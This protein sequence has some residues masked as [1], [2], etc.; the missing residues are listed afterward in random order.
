[1]ESRKIFEGLGL[2]KKEVVERFLVVTREIYK[3]HPA[4]IFDE[5]ESKTEILI[6]PSYA[7]TDRDGKQPRLIVKAGSYNYHLMDTIYNNMSKEVKRNG[8]VAGY[9]HSQILNIPLTVL[10]HSYA[11]EE[12]SDLADEL[13]SL[14][15]YACRKM[16]SAKGLV[17]RGMQ[18]SETDLFNNDQKIYQT[19]ASIS[20]DVPWTTSTVDLSAPIQGIELSPVIEEP[21][22]FPTYRSPG[23]AVI[24]EKQ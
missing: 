12:S 14:V 7:D 18:V 8:S 1:M 4:Y 21:L 3:H 17:V 10:I 6:Y 5:D 11:E 9:E 16:Y 22:I 24:K 19:T 15:V 2:F 13:A 23:V 20:F